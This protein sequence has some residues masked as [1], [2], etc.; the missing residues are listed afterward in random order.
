MNVLFFVTGETPRRE[1]GGEVGTVAVRTAGLAM[2]AKQREFSE[3]SMVKTLVL[4]IVNSVATFTCC[5]KFSLMHV[6]KCM[7]SKTGGG[8]ALVDFTDMT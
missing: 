8:N 2:R 7:T 3:F 4:P 6:L 1:L 5:A